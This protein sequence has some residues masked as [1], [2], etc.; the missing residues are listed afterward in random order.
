MGVC[1]NHKYIIKSVSF[2]DTSSKDN[3]VQKAI[4]NKYV[5]ENN[6][7]KM[8]KI[9]ESKDTKLKEKDKIQLSPIG[10]SEKNLIN[11]N[12]KIISY[13]IHSKYK[14]KFFNISPNK[15]NNSMCNFVEANKDQFNNNNFDNL[16]HFTSFFDKKNCSA[17]TATNSNIK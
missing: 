16:I 4:E 14:S 8:E 9:E 6:K 11:K 10:I 1:L 12:N 5:K 13:Q 15:N 2:D 7:E 17:T 3:K